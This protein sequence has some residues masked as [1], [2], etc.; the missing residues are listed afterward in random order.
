MIHKFVRIS[1]AWS[2]SEHDEGLSDIAFDSLL[3]NSDN[4]ES[5]GLSNWSALADGDDITGSDSWESWRDMGW[6]VVMSLLE[7][8]VLLDVMEVISS[9]DNGSVHLVGENNT[10]KDS[11][12]DGDVGGEWALVVNIVAL[13]GSLWGLEAKADLLVESWSLGGLLGDHLLRVLENSKLFLESS[14]GLDREVG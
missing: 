4:I 5:D 8:V 13:N 12:T 7:P 2:R 11:T 14:F 1:S 9:E 3:L 10:L 6:E